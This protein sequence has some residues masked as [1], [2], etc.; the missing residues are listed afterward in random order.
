MLFNTFQFAA[1]FTLVYVLYRA[2]PSDRR[3]SLLL[4][5]SFVFYTLWIPAYFLLLL[6]DLVVNFALMRAMHR[7]PRPGLLLGVSVA[8][9]L[10]L[11]GVFKYAAMFVETLLPVLS[12][13][14]G[15]TPDLPDIF[16]PLGI[17]FYSF[18]IIALQVDVYRRN[19]EPVE[20]FSRYAL[21]ISFFPQLIAGPILR[22]HEFL[23]QLE[24]GGEMTR[25]RNRRGLWLVASGLTK[26]VILADFLL[27]PYV[28]EIFATPEIGTT[29]LQLIAIY[30]FAFQIYFDFSGYCDIARGLALWLGFELPGN[31]EEPYLSKDP[32]EFWRRWHITLSRWLRDYIFVPV[33]S[34]RGGTGAVGALFITMFLGGLW[35]GAAWTFALWGM[36]HGAL[37]ILHRVASPLLSRI[38][39][40]AGVARLAWDGLCIFVTFQ[41]ICLGLAIFR[42]ASFEDALAIYGTVL[43][44]DFTSPWPAFQTTLVVLCI[45][46]HFAERVVRLRLP[47]IQTAVGE[48]VFGPLVEGLAF[49]TI[50]ALAIAASGSGGEFIYFQ[51]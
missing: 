49:G 40:R 7:S 19:A 18:Q 36:Y 14:F 41:L 22:G 2:S 26:K 1:F 39:P 31:F 4:G 42:A 46:L 37:L 51:F 47:Q 35:H 27:A 38:T 8:F 24:R 17:S 32:A 33:S 50:V 10:G 20:T 12:S 43:S 3:G 23:G 6:A 28:D 30:S 11:L 45:A 29:A 25:Q 13:S 16:L 5:A 9:T 21:F 44:F 48:R 34:R 15:W